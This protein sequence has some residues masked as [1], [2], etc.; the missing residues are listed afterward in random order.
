MDFI[1]VLLV[2]GLAFFLVGI[3]V[4]QDSMK[5]DFTKLE[6]QLSRLEREVDDLARRLY[7]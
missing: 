4:E 1:I 2:L 6:R 3:F 5:K 7:D